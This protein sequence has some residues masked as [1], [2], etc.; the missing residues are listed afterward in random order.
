MANKRL[1]KEEELLLQDFS[2]NVSTKS[3]ALFYG[4]AFVVSVVPLWLF[5]RIHGQ[6]VSASFLIWIFM[7]FV[8]TWLMAFAYR[9]VKFIL[10]HQIA[11]KREDGVTREIMKQYSDDKK[12]NKKDRDERILWKKNEVADFE[13]TMLSMFFNNALFTFVMIFVSFYLFGNT[14]GSWNYVLS[15]GAASGLA[16]LFSTG[17]K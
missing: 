5:W 11:Q 4:N 16:A 12:M 17:T 2:R 8:S 13:A 7:T 10:K 14:T 9:N 3:S 6:E 15:I 1:T